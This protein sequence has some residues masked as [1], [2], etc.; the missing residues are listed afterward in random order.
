MIFSTSATVSSRERALTY[1]LRM[2]YRLGAGVFFREFKN[3]LTSLSRKNYAHGSNNQLQI[4]PCGELL[5]AKQVKVDPRIESDVAS[6]ATR[7]LI[8]GETG[9]NLLSLALIVVVGLNLSQRA[10]SSAEALESQPS[11]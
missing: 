3:C 5:D 7:L 10:C 2:G 9:F 8:A 4:T 11:K 1:V 6:V